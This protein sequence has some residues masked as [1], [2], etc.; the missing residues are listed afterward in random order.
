M[1]KKMKQ[2]ILPVLMSV[3]LAF[4]II[5]PTTF[6]ET[7]SN[8]LVTSEFSINSSNILELEVRDSITNESFKTSILFE[9]GTEWN[10]SLLKGLD[11][12]YIVTKNEYRPLSS[13]ESV[14]SLVVS[15]DE[16]KQFFVDTIF[17]IG[18]F[19][20]SLA[21]FVA[22]PSLWTGL[23][24]VMDGAAVVL[25]GVPSV[26]GVKRMIGASSTLKTALSYDIKKYG[27][28]QNV[29]I[30]SGW[31]RHHI[32]EKRFAGALGT[33]SYSML[34]IAIPKTTHSKITTKMGQKIK[35]GQDYTK[36]SQTY[37][38][39][40]HIAG[41]KELYNETGDVV[42]EFLWKFSESKQ[43]TARQ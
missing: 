13:N 1:F 9:N 8:E 6:A 5:V 25:P 40:Q 4:G 23:N 11:S 17:D 32:F 16:Y 36:L 14:P 3:I 18:N 10:K 27:Q 29:T 20:I 39:N 38:M 43:H 37:I 7:T 15:E 35:T 24:V 41:Y 28:L 30:P 2:S 26:V 34:A 19:T 31:E 33:T 42:Y 22:S 21:E 12:K